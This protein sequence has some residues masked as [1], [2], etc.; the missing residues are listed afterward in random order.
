MTYAIAIEDVRMEVKMLKAL[1][2]YTH[3]VKF[4][5]VCKDAENVYIVME[6]VS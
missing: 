2:G 5:D 6:Y 1:S 3:T 4:Y